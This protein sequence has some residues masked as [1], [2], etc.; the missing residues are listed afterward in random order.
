MDEEETRD[1][2]RT[3]AAAGLCPMTEANLGD[4]IF[5]GRDYVEAGGRFGIGTD[6]NVSISASQELRQLEYSQRLSARARNIL[7]PAGGSS[8]RALLDAALH[9]GAQAIA[10]PAGRLAG[11]AVADIL[12]LN[13]EH[14]T[15]A[16]KTGDRILDA[17]IFSVGDQLVD[18][19]FSGGR[20]M[21][22]QGRHFAR[23]RVAARFKATMRKRATE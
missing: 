17:W 3:G 18:C 11:G 14:P 9:G 1:L 8:G 13:A 15:L 2:A 6:S 22:A 21:V 20:K 5:N 19:V 7:A 10:R 16:G 12:T 4:G 23:E